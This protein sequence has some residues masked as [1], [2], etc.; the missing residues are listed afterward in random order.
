[1]VGIGRG[2]KEGI[3]IKNAAALEQAY[4]VE[5]LIVDKT[6]TL[7]E[8]KPNVVDSLWYDINDEDK[9]A[10]LALE[11]VSEH[12]LAAAIVE[13]LS[14]EELPQ[15]TV[16]QF[17][18]IPG[19]GVR[20]NIG[21]STY[22]L[23]NKSTIAQAPESEQLASW[24]ASGHTVIFASKDGILKGMFAIADRLRADAQQ[25]VAELQKLGI[26]VHMLTGDQEPTARHIAGATGIQSVHA[27]LLP[28]EKGA[29]VKKLQREGK[30]VAMA[31]DGINDA[32]ALAL[33][34]VGIAMGSG[35]DIA[36]ESAGIT[37]MHGRIGQIPEAIRLS[38]KT[39]SRI[40]QNLFW[41]FIYNIIAVPIAAGALYPCCD[42][43]LSPMIA[44]GAMA[45]SSVSVVLNSLRK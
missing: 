14:E 17:D 40:N 1:M 43:L 12:P 34:D 36:M 16:D 5:A 33:A 15:A 7:T 32:E 4:Q 45:M 11:K 24:E 2:A 30:V 20:G 28:E 26:E 23:G 35:T 25:A 37:L 44:G 9:A 38:R 10:F 18:I 39:V 13:Y 8:G 27:G 41:A 3:L 6:G 29:F 21:G 22:F 31:G 42:F 19:Q